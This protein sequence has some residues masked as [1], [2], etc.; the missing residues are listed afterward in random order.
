MFHCILLCLN[1]VLAEFPLSAKE[2]G[3]GV[4][5]VN[6]G[7]GLLKCH[8]F[9]KC[10]LEFGQMHVLIF[11]ITFYISDKY[12]S[13]AVAVMPDKERFSENHLWTCTKLFLFCFLSNFWEREYFWEAKSCYFK[14]IQRGQ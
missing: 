4:E 2:A 6:P 13:N 9:D 8:N 12:S 5:R 11:A 3:P 14:L 7:V 1:R 10:I